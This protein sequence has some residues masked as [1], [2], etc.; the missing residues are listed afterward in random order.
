MSKDP[1]DP[2]DRLI[3]AI[4]RLAA[5]TLAAALV[6]PDWPS[7]KVDDTYLGVLNGTI[8][9]GRDLKELMNRL[10]QNPN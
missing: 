5:A 2:I 1:Q 3:A 8:H 7:K 6:E 9:E 10:N 4:D